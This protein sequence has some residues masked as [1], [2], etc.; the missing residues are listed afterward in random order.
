M[1]TLVL[2]RPLISVSPSFRQVKV[3]TVSLSGD[4]RLGH[5]WSAQQPAC[6]AQSRNGVETHD[7]GVR[8][9][10]GNVVTSPWVAPLRPERE[11]HRE[12]NY[13]LL[14]GGVLARSGW[15]TISLHRVEAGDGVLRLVGPVP[16]ETFRSLPGI[17]VYK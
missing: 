5:T 17:A 14:G 4:W 9:Y 6:K 2:G 8:D 16:A 12:V 15:Q 11:P 1:K 7:A 13:S 3:L 10:G